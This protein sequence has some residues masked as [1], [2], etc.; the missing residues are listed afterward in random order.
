[1]TTTL[2]PLCWICTRRKGMPG[3]WTCEAFPEASP[4]DIIDSTWDHR[5]PKGHKPVFDT[6]DEKAATYADL[7]FEA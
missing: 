5:Q 2:M 1:M 3:E 7:L 6:V 4:E